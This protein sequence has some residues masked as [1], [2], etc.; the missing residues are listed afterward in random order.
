MYTLIQGTTPTH[1]F[2]LPSSMHHIVPTVLYITYSQ[3]GAVRLEKTL[4]DV[5]IAN[6]II[7]TQLTQ[8]DT[9]AFKSPYDIQV[10]I[11]FRTGDGRAYASNVVTIGVASSLKSGVI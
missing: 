7:S 5:T 4:T 6:G 11:R 9:N 8:E 3:R 10:Q 2:T 1:R